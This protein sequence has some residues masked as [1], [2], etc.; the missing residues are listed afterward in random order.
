MPGLNL[1]F[2]TGNRETADI[3]IIFLTGGNDRESV[4]RIVKHKPDGCLLKTSRNDANKKLTPE[5]F[6]A[7]AFVHKITSRPH[8][9]CAP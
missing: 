2:G 3:P 4:M 5:P 7:S 6:Q 8:T 9:A 1:S